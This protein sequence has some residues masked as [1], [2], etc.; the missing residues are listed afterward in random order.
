VERHLEIE[1]KFDVD[2]EFLLPDLAGLPH[3][4][5]VQ[6]LR[7]QRLVATYF[8]TEDLR[9]LRS[10]AT[11]RR[12]TGGSDS[13]WH[14]KLPA[15]AQR[16]LELRRP[17]GRPADGVPEELV[18]LTR[19]RTRA[20]E[21]GPVA[22]LTTRRRVHRLLD[23]EGTV[24]AE[25]ADDGV[26]AETMGEAVTTTAWRE[27]EV[28]LVDGTPELL[29]A[30]AKA[31]RRAGAKASAKE[32]KLA[33]ALSDRLEATG[34][35]S[36]PAAPAGK[37]PTAGDVALAHVREQIEELQSRDP[38]VRTETDDAV[39]KMRVATRRLRSA[40]ATF[41]PLFD[42]EVTD[43]LRE[44][45]KW[46]GGVLGEARDAEVMHEHLTGDLETLPSELVL[47][48]VAKRL[49]D[50]L[51]TTYTQAFADVL[52][53][54][55]GERYLTLLDRLVVLLADP[56]LSKVATKKAEKVLEK[57]VQH[58]LRRVQ[59][60]AVEADEAPD[61]EQRDLRMHEVRKAAKRA[62]YAGESVSS[63]FGKRA[64]KFAAGMESIQEILG[65][66]QDSIVAQRV[67]LDLGAR[68]HLDGDNAF[69]YGVLVGL[70]RCSADAT[71]ADYAE[72]WARVKA[73]GKKWPG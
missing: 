24:L 25:V 11:L 14:L 29:A 65:A 7:L 39:H 51:R 3:V 8:D 12:R 1:A 71:A 73:A 6:S 55:D 47:G 21:L 4:A 35:P 69:T 70:Q 17:P 46:L 30:A 44:E 34:P 68:A 61:A 64:R 40:L 54:L 56:P 45:L 19:S 31:L 62:R 49:E 2:E 52:V 20:A 15:G 18:A 60:A 37:R 9:L 5:D 28:E 26:T 48:T 57:R 33:R 23:A 67:L 27:V 42:R 22:R 66:H 32:S 43:P 38:D 41:R 10:S 50:D 72:V 36:R 13:G 16:R 58:T 63:V 53:E 59:R